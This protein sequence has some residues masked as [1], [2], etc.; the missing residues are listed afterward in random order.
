MCRFSESQNFVQPVSAFG[1]IL[2]CFPKTKQRRA[3]TQSPFCIAS[4]YEPI[5]GRAKIVLF[6]REAFQPIR[7]HSALLRSLFR[8][9]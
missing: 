8:Q 5:E 7:L 1:K 3:Q 9:Y 4:F 2:G 6:Q